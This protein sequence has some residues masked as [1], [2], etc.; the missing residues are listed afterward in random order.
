MKTLAVG[1]IFALLIS[2]VAQAE[3]YSSELSAISLNESS[4]GVYKEHKRMTKG[5][6]KGT[7]A[8]G[9]YGLMPLTAKDIVRGNPSL[10]AKYGFLLT[11]DNDS[12]TGALNTN[13]SMDREIATTM[14]KGLRKHL[15]RYRAA[16]AWLNG[17]KRAGTLSEEVIL[18]HY[19]VQRFSHGFIDGTL[20]ASRK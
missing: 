3:D 18:G 15:D 12:V 6:H 4:G 9:S 16:Y 20:H 8:A 5:M 1:A 7:V 13:A 19:Y 10:K 17:S 2:G 14:W 11:M